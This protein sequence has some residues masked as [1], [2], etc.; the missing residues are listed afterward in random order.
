MRWRRAPAA[1]GEREAEGDNGVHEVGA[2][3]SDSPDAVEG[4]F[5]GQEDSAGGDEQRDDGD[6]LNFAA[7]VG[8]KAMFWTTKS[9]CAGRK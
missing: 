5:E 3:F 4:D 6:D 1:D 9:W 8:E 7:G 2:V